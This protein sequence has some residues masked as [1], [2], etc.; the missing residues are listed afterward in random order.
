MLV[1]PEREP[2]PDELARLILVNGFSTR[3][4]TTQVSGRGV[5]M[6]V[7]YSRILDMKGRLA[8]NSEFGSGLSVE[9]RLPATL[10]SAHT[11]VV[12]HRNKLIAVSSHGVE[13]IHYVTPDQIEQVG[14]QQFYRVG[15]TV[16][17]LI[18]LE[19]LVDLPDDRRESG[20]LGFPV[21]LTRADNGV[22]T[23]VLVQEVISDQEVVLKNFGR[24][25]PK[26]TGMV[27]AVILGD[28]TVAPVVD[29]V[30]LLRTPAQRLQRRRFASADDTAA[31]ETSTGTLTALVVDDSLSARRAASAVMQD[32]GYKVR[33]AIDGL[34]AVG[35]LQ[36]FIP[37]VMLVDMEMPRM[38]GIEL[39]SHV[40]D[41]ARTKNVP[42]IMITS[43]STE[44]HRKMCKD[45]GV[46]VYLTKP[47]SDD[48]LIEHV[49]RLVHS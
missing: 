11:L 30:E 17:S 3:E 2:S 8:L 26:I 22:A 25:V 43:R 13:D 41:S 35:I 48:V 14:S 47:Y 24:Y 45:A 4:D 9:L 32:A 29:L 21:L 42:V 40:R 31:S 7:V 28:G 36:R 44:K 1:D 23:G 46:D 39:T 16:H 27:G 10:L 5:G 12:R 38:N 19:M 34:E 33:T 6:N 18:S 15:D 37:S 20:R 49:Q